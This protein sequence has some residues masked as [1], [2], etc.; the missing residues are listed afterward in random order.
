M[1]C[2]VCAEGGREVPAVG[3][4]WHCTAGLCLAHVHETAQQHDK[5]MYP[6]CHHDM[7]N[8]ARPRPVGDDPR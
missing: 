8:P 6:H 4:C 1:N 5:G 3:L 2:W 7:W